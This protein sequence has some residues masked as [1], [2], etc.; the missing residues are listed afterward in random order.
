MGEEH[1]HTLIAALN[2]ALTLTSLERL[3]EAKTLLRKTTPVAR[4]V[5]G[6]NNES[7]LRLR[8]IYAQTLYDDSAATVDDLREAVTILEATERTARR[9]FGGAHPLTA[10]TEEDL[11]EARAARRA[12]ETPPDRV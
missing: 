5:L 8:W 6:E 10:G 7:T 1:E 11:R 2:Y 9:V 12:R 3:E 4:R